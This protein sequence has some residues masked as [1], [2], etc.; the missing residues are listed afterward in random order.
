MI[1]LRSWHLGK[2]LDKK[3]TSESLA[4]LHDYLTYIVV[5]QKQA[6]VFFKIFTGELREPGDADKED[7]Q[8]A[9]WHCPVPWLKECEMFPVDVYFSLFSE[10]APTISHSKSKETYI[11][12][13]WTLPIRRWLGAGANPSK[14][15]VK[16][17]LATSFAF[18]LLWA[19]WL[20]WNP[21][22]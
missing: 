11:G 4:K 1:Y 13:E 20:F 16:A 22:L 21:H 8:D 2:W 3:W 7:L 15:G 18:D 12:V 6:W 9:A 17:T 10:L 19:P 14:M 5:V